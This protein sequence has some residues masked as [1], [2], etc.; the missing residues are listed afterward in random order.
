MDQG[1]SEREYKQLKKDH[2]I[3]D[4]GVT[5]LYIAIISIAF[6]GLYDDISGTDIGPNDNTIKKGPAYGG[7]AILNGKGEPI[8]DPT[9]RDIRE[10]VK[11]RLLE[12][13]NRTQALFDAAKTL[14][15]APEAVKLEKNFEKAI[16][17]AIT[18]V[19]VGDFSQAFDALKLVA[20]E[21]PQINTGEKL[22]ASTPEAR[23][24][25]EQAKKAA[26]PLK[27][28]FKVVQWVKITGGKL[29]GGA[30]QGRGQ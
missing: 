11:R 4:L 24:L 17:E 12:T 2:P 9:G 6:K 27:D 22:I 1:K 13:K 26:E 8:A 25:I 20:D 29:P 18:R 21:A 10:D 16:D 30:G 7:V 14:S 19:N 28:A 5:I 23:T 15:D 3:K